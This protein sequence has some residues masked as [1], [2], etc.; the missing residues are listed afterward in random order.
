MYRRHRHM[1]RYKADDEK[2]R[3][4]EREPD[5]CNKLRPAARRLTAG[6]LIFTCPHSI[7]HG[8]TLLRDAESVRD[9]FQVLFTR[10]DNRTSVVQ[11]SPLIVV[12]VAPGLVFYDNGC[13]LHTFCVRREPFFFHSTVFRIDYIHFK[14]HVGCPE[15]YNPQIYRQAGT[16]SADSNAPWAN[17]EAAEQAFSKVKTI[18]VAASF[19]T[20]Q[21]CMEYLR[22]FFALRN[23]ATKAKAEAA[24]K[25]K[26][27]KQS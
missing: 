25:A 14:G 17:S 2:E 7:V 9:I 16:S 6:L 8:F 1:R 12:Y 5:Q 27:A 22:T 3:A 23:L 26:A 4:E 21:H 18:K 15:G 19:M 24:T 11:H 13:K 20:E 10:F